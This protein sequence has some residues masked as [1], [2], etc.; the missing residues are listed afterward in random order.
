MVGGKDG[1]DDGKADSGAHMPAAL[2]LAALIALPDDLPVRL[3]NR[4]S[5]IGDA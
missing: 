3:G 5:R 2:M 1:A 4:F